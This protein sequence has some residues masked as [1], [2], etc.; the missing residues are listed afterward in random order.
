MC[1]TLWP[2]APGGTERWPV[3]ISPVIPR[4]GEPLHV[5]YLHISRSSRRF[6]RRSKKQS[7]SIDRKGTGDT[8]YS[9]PGS[10]KTKAQAS[11]VG[12]IVPIRTRG[13]PMSEQATVFVLDRTR[14]QPLTECQLK[15]AWKCSR[16]FTVF[17]AGPR[18]RLAFQHSTMTR[19]P[20]GSA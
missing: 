19:A 6:A 8:R 15:E 12:C 17:D 4:Q 2:G 9:H 13:L 20:L 10:R 18:W 1:L 14:V 16:R 5:W 3:S 11:Q 7:R